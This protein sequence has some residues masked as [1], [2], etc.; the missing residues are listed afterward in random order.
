VSAGAWPHGDPNAVVR[1]ILAQPAFR[2]V[3]NATADAG[4]S[5]LERFTQWLDG[6]IGPF[7]QRLLEGSGD[8]AAGSILMIVLYAVAALALLFVVAFGAEAIVGW[9]SRRSGVAGA[10][11]TPAP[12]HSPEDLRRRASEAAQAGDFGRAIALLFRAALLLL[13]RATVLAFDTARTPGEYRRL[14]RRS[15][16]PAASPFDE[17]ALRFVQAAFGTKRPDRG[18]YEAAARAYATFAPHAATQ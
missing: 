15:L 17:L 9:S 14:V 10:R 2:D 8:G 4:G 5:A 11:G 16:A 1:A 13:D 7:F 6:L 3:R 18:D 12:S